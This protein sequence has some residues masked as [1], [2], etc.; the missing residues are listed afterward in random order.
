[1]IHQPW[2]I[3]NDIQQQIELEIGNSYPLPILDLNITRQQA[4]ATAKAAIKRESA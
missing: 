1:L 3:N 2:K 4:I